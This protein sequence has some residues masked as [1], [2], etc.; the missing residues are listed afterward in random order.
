[1]LTRWILSFR[2]LLGRRHTV[3][4]HFW[5][6]LAVY[7]QQGFGLLLG[8]LLARILTPQD[9]GEYAFASATLLLAILP[10]S[11]SIAPL[12]LSDAGR[13]PSLFS[14]IMGFSW[15]TVAAK[16]FFTVV[17]T[18]VL[19][20]LG[21]GRTAGLVA[22]I[23]FVESSR[24]IGNVLMYDLHARGEFVYNFRA[25]MISVAL[26][27]LLAIP[28]AFSGWGAFA[29]VLPGLAGAGAYLVVFQRA[30]RRRIWQPVPWGRLAAH[31]TNGFWLWIVGIS[32]TVFYRID[33]W[34]VGK[35][36]GAV[37]LAHYSR[38]YNYAPAS[39]MALSSLTT[40]ATISAFARAGGRAQR[41][42]LAVRTWLILFSGG[43]LNWIILDLWADRL[44]P[45]VFGGQWV[46]AVPIFR[47]FG[48]FAICCGTFYLTSS[49]LIALKDFRWLAC[50]RLFGALGFGLSLFCLRGVLDTLM[51]ASLVQAFMLVQGLLMGGRCRWY[52][53]N[54]RL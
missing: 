14:E 4:A 27:F 41:E 5:Q 1:M 23:G 24:E 44:V 47:A 54:Q 43:V 39:Y 38:A 29:L 31:L 17:T 21:H 46:P 2:E 18:L 36:L 48:P 53:R 26:A 15:F 9:F 30:T 33:N 28:A 19:L 22:F 40:N 7:V 11:W 32:Q 50:L 10:A 51:V 34:C 37:N 45:W 20:G 6:T 16:G 52:L 8:V 49:L 35:F 12:L 3:R 13:T 25:E 42:R